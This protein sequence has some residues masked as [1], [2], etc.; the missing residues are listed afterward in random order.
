MSHTTTPARFHW[1]ALATGLTAVAAL[2][3]AGCAAP[4][5]SYDQP[6]VQAAPATVYT[7]PTQQAPTRDYRRRSN[8]QLYQADVLSVH[9]VLSER[10]RGLV[11]ARAHPTLQAYH[12]PSNLLKPRIDLEHIWKA[13]QKLHSSIYWYLQAQC[14][15]LSC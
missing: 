6:V 14:V 3:G 5:R 7:Y 9:L 15:R 11:D 10:S 13:H 2:T 12:R 1:K 4:Y 8:E